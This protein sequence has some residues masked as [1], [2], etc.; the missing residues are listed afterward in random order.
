MR[1]T[2]LLSL[3]LFVGT[4]GTAAACSERQ[5]D[6]PTAPAARAAVTT[7]HDV[8]SAPIP[9]AAK[10]VPAPAGF[11]RI[12]TVETSLVQVPAT[13]ANTGTAMCP[14]GTTVV[15]GG[16]TFVG[17]NVMVPP[18]V[19]TSKAVAGGWTVDVHNQAVGASG[20][21]SFYVYANCAS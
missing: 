3:S 12:T 21:A 7:S 15:S 19:R 4:L 20:G 16:Y 10:P 5:P 2:T 11:T 6:S 9:G 18:W 14:A 13:T 8:A 1:R 17:Y